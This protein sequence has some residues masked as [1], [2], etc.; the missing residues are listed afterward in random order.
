[1][2]KLEIPKNM[3]IAMIWAQDLSA[4][5]GDGKKIPWHVPD[6]LKHFKACTHGYP[7]VMGKNNYLSLTKALSGRKNVVIS[8]SLEHLDDAQV[9]SSPQAAID[10]LSD[11]DKIWIVGGAQIY[12]EFM[13]YAHELVVSYLDFCR[14]ASIKAPKI[15]DSWIVNS[16]ASDKKFRPQ[17]GEGRFK[18]VSFIRRHE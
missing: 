6:D 10:Y 1:M 14:P 8:T 9:V 15:D 18:V 7:V 17:S 4:S 12:K 3:H 5:L 13:P 2:K 16:K 11:S